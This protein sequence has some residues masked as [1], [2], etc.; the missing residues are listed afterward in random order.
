MAMNGDFPHWHR[1]A[2]DRAPHHI[3]GPG[4]R[5]PPYNIV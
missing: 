4:N 5:L 1:G 2:G 3:T